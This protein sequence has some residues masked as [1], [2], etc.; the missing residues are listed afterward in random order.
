MYMKANMKQWLLTLII[1]LMLPLGSYAV[2]GFDGPIWYDYKESFPGTGTFLDP[3][4]ISTPGQL[5]QL[6]Y[7]VNE[8]ITNYAGKYIV[9]GADIDLNK[10]VN[11]KRVQWIPI[12]YKMK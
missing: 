3:Y 4:V 1:L 5:A 11:G 10:T 12:G 7:D 9:L 6:S 2:E 8:G